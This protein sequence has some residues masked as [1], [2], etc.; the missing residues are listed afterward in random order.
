MKLALKIG[1]TLQKRVAVVQF[2]PSPVNA[3]VPQPATMVAYGAT[4]GQV[5]KEQPEYPGFD[6]FLRVLEELNA[7]DRN[8]HFRQVEEA[9]EEGLR[10]MVEEAEPALVVLHKEAFANG[11]WLGGSVV[12]R[13]V[14]HTHVPVLALEGDTLPQSFRNIV[15]PTDVSR[16]LPAEADFMA[17]WVDA[18][19]ATVHLV[20][21][22]H[23]DLTDETEVKKKMEKVALE[24]G[25]ERFFVN[26]SHHDK[27]VEAIV[28]FSEKVEAD[29]IMMKTYDK[30]N[31]ERFL[32]GSIT[33]DMIKKPSPA[34][35]AV[36]VTRT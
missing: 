28:D 3:L 35:L 5:V 10:T 18:F 20:N 1:K 25:F 24:L 14:R 23:T 21:V 36:N 32:F 33:E 29:L 13:I 34:V 9:P 31:F 19:N 27:E 7:L 8:I 26:T 15:L 4:V 12:Q 22:I 16:F 2:V 11:A 6:D 17:E 30:N